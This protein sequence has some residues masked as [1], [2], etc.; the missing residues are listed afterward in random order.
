[1]T[2]QQLIDRLKQLPPGA[3]IEIPI[4]TYTQKYPAVYVQ[5]TDWK[6]LKWCVSESPANLNKVRITVHTPE[7][8]VI[9]NRNK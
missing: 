7:G 4:Q 3:E 1:M 6:D 5:T 8:I 9:V 2:V